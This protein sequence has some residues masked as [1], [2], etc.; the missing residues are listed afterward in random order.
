MSSSVHLAIM[1]NNYHRLKLLIDAGMSVNVRLGL[2][3][4]LDFYIPMVNLPSRNHHNLT[5]LHLAC[6]KGNT[7]M[8]QLLI[9][10]VIKN[11]NT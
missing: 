1:D 7:K 9:R 4:Y 8:V 5:P 3:Y 11:I 10:Y 2:N 6:C